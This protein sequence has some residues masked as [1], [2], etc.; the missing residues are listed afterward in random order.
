MK[1]ILALAILIAAGCAPPGQRTGGDETRRPAGPSSEM[2]TYSDACVADGLQNWILVAYQTGI[3]EIL[4]HAQTTSASSG[5]GGVRIESSAKSGSVGTK[6]SHEGVDTSGRS[7]SA[8]SRSD[9]TSAGQH[10]DQGSAKSS[11]DTKSSGLE[12]DQSTAKTRSDSTKSGQESDSRTAKTTSDESR[13]DQDSKSGTART[14]T[15]S[16]GTDVDSTGETVKS[17]SDPM[18]I[19]QLARGRLVIWAKDVLEMF[20]RNKV[21]VQGLRTRNVDIL[22]VEE[23][24]VLGQQVSVVKAAKTEAADRSFDGMLSAAGA[25]S[26]RVVAYTLQLKNISKQAVTGVKMIDVLPA[27][28]ELDPSWLNEV[29]KRST[30]AEDRAIFE[31]FKDGGRTVIVWGVRESVPSGGEISLTFGTMKR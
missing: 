31:V 27:G 22:Q 8:G 14:K 4:T 6:S 30:S 21:D 29:M 18:A 25:E 3:E 23:S 5:S 12:T 1:K 26:G 17:G 7:G 28:L 15:D 11:S 13:S 20:Q 2:L 19:D 16:T 9:S 24:F 10:T